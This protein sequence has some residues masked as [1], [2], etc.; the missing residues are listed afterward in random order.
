MPSDPSSLELRDCSNASIVL[1]EPTVTDAAHLVPGALVNLD[2]VF[3]VERVIDVGLVDGCPSV[4]RLQ[5]IGMY[6]P[7]GSSRFVA[8][9][10]HERVLVWS[11]TG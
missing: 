2:P 7:E 8:R 9:F 3:G 10:T 4:V 6:A 5:V 1:N 11:V